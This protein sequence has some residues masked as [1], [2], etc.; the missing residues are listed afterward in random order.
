MDNLFP[1]HK[2]SFTCL[3]N[4]VDIAFDKNES[5][6][7]NWF[8]E[9]HNIER[10]FFTKSCT[11]SLE[12]SLMLLRLPKGAEVIMPSYA[13]VSVANAVTNLGY[14]AV[15]V[16]CEKHTMNIDVKAVKGAVSSLTRAIISINYGGVSCDYAG[17]KKICE[18]HKLYLIE[19][20]A[21]GILGKYKSSLLGTQGDIST[22]S[23]DHLKNFT[24]FQGGGI[25]INNKALLDN[26]FIA[27][28]FGTNRHDCLNGKVSHYEWI[29]QGSNGIIAEPLKYILKTQLLQSEEIASKFNSNWKLYQ[30]KMQPLEK[31]GV[32]ALSQTPKYATRSAH[33]F[34]FKTAD[35]DE[36]KKLMAFLKKKGV[37]SM[38]HYEPLHNSQYGREIGEF[39]GDDKYTTIESK[40]L[41]RLPLYLSLS[42]KDIE[43][44]VK[45]VRSFYC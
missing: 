33:M 14:K 6:C 25:G 24:C 29:A 15:F 23:F 4:K 18:K 5:F 20:N 11:Q 42:A 26:F 3:T 1:F 32:I 13:F 37:P 38:S 45:S 19:D 31:K 43:F 21:H 35:P 10:F 40:K 30:D 16:D 7:K 28:E 39:R 27:A 9:K 8:A 22:F 41:L 44:I 17:L 2:N 34:W 36:R 12:L